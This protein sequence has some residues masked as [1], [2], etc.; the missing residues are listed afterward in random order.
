MDFG[1]ILDSVIGWVTTTGVRLLI[2]VILLVVGFKAINFTVGRIEKRASHT[3]T[4]KTVA[5]VLAYA[6]RL[7][8]KLVLLVALV[9]YVGIDT[10][11]L[12]ALVASLGVSVGLALNGALSNL[13]GGVLIILTRPFRV[14][15]YIEAQ[16][17]SGTVMDI[18]V[19]YTRLKTP[20]NKIVYLPNGA[21]ST[22]N[23]VNYSE[24]ALR[25]IDL[26][27]LVGYSTGLGEVKALLSDFASEND[28]VLS[29]P[30][31]QLVVCDQS[32]GGLGISLRLWVNS[33]DYWAVRFALMGR[34]AEAMEQGIIA[35]PE[36]RVSIEKT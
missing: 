31:H 4:D 32:E 35:A 34:V 30:P 27:L 25:R 16:S 17:H 26:D 11:G 6:L 18:H 23:I 19:T 14:D 33:E 8:L 13:A 10:G 22:G 2:A 15:D 12:A 9:G 3:R 20:D 36:R 29:T 5:R 28:A 24:Q 1:A 21:L 7:G